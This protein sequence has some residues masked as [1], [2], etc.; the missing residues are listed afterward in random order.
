[1]AM[2]REPKAKVPK[3][4]V[5]VLQKLAPKLHT[6]TSFLFQVQYHLAKTPAKTISPKAL[7]NS[8]DHRKPKMLYQFI[9]LPNQPP[10]ILLYFVNWQV[11][12]GQ[13]L[14]AAAKISGAQVSFS[15]YLSLVSMLKQ[16]PLLKQISDMSMS[17]TFLEIHW[18]DWS[19]LFPA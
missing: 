19:R 2:T 4:K 18:P 15:L 11:S 17:S 7:T 1:M 8:I 12:S 13:D 3:W 10:P 14:Q 16:L 5:N 6:G 9:Q